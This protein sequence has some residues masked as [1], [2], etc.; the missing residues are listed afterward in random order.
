MLKYLRL[1]N[2]EGNNYFS[3]SI[4]HGEMEHTVN[5]IFHRPLNHIFQLNELLLRGVRL[6]KFTS[7]PS[8]ATQTVLNNKRIIWLF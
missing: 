6:V 5:Y 2:V 4:S 8:L 7:Q 1:P 3:S